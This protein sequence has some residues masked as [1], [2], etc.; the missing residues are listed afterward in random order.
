M[1]RLVPPN[2]TTHHGLKADVKYLWINIYS[3]HL[4]GGSTGNLTW[5]HRRNNWIQSFIILR[6][7]CHL[8]VTIILHLIKSKH[9]IWFKTYIFILFGPNN[10]SKHFFE[11]HSI[12]NTCPYV[13]P[14]CCYRSCPFSNICLYVLMA[15]Q[16]TPLYQWVQK[17]GTT[18]RSLS[19][20]GG[21]N[22]C[23]KTK[24]TALFWHCKSD[25]WI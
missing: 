24:L 25:A 12:T 6:Q 15:H 16:T 21:W 23:F 8:L 2:M 3:W 22:H 9:F 19:M 7:C 4:P 11:F 20:G 18:I 14:D 5:M 17:L 10:A 13:V 1:L